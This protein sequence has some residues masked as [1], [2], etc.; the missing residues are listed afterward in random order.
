MKIDFEQ[1]IKDVKEIVYKRLNPE[2]WEGFG[3]Y[4]NE[5]TFYLVDDKYDYK[6]VLDIWFSK[7][8]T[9]FALSLND[10]ENSWDDFLP[11]SSLNVELKVEWSDTFTIEEQTNEAL[12]KVF[13]KFFMALTEPMFKVMDILK[14]KKDE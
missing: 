10:P 8:Y 12:D 13:E 14:K 1:L 2:G 9:F 4:R 6:I 7:S 3:G 11:G 5:L